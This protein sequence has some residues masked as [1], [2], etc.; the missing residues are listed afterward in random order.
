MR[1]TWILLAIMSFAACSLYGAEPMKLTDPK[2]HQVEQAFL[3]YVEKVPEW[4]TA[5]NC[6]SMAAEKPEG[7]CWVMLRYLHMPL[8]AYRFTGDTRYLDM[9]VEAF[10]R[11]RAA[12]TEGADGYLGW[13]GKPLPLFRN[14]D[15]PDVKVDVIISSF[16]AVMV[17]SEF[18][19]L[20]DR[21]PVLAHKYARQRAEYLRLCE[22]HLVKKWDARGNYMD[23]GKTGAVYRTHADLRDVKALLTQPHNKH[24]LITQALLGLY[25]ATGKDEH[26]RKAIKLGTRF[27]HCLSLK[28][29]HYVWNYWDYAGPWDIDP[30]DRTKWKHWIG[31]EHKSTY[32]RLSV[33][34]AVALYHHGV[35]F[36]RQDIDR[37]LKTQLEVTW[38]GDPENP[39]WF[40]V[41]GQQPWNQESPYMAEALAPFEPKLERFVYFGRGRD[42]RIENTANAW[43]GGVG[44]DAWLVGKFRKLPRAKGGRQ[45]YLEAGNRFREKEENR[46]FLDSL[47]FSVVAPGYTFSWSPTELKWNAQ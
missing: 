22:D 11:M 3:G 29:G 13:Y 8:T 12:M 15:E 25:R 17:L 21:D 39:Q 20:V 41:D 34:M 9:F 32:Y 1:R 19:E 44:A 42:A 10:A 26:M 23:L 24:S 43:Q 2:D 4:T 30:E 16:R 6:K 47:Q 7:Y 18:A 36:D 28:D 27:K 5:A 35:V 46:R 14:P 33:S 38:N 45:M 40:K 37:F 31:P